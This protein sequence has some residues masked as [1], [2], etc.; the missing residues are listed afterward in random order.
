MASRRQKLR[1]SKFEKK[2]NRLIFFINFFKGGD[3]F[4]PATVVLSPGPGAGI[5]SGPGSARGPSAVPGPCP[6]P[7]AGSGLDPGPGAGPGEGL[8]RI[9]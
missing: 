3:C 4:L 1:N 8:G 7:G 5:G 6:G 2:K 9:F